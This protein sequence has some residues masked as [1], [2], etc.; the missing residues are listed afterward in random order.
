MNCTKCT[1]L[2]ASRTKIVQPDTPDFGRPCKLL[3]I[4]EAPG[5]DEDRQGK[6][7]VG[8]SGKVLHLLLEEHGLRRGYEYGCANIVRCRPPGNRK[9]TAAEIENCLPYLADTILQAK[10]KA[11]LLI[12][13]TATTVFLGGGALFHHVDASRKLPV[14]R[15]GQFSPAHPVLAEGLAAMEEIIAIPMPHT[16]PLAWNRKDPNGTRWS[17]IGREQ[18]ERVARLLK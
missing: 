5:S 12:G 14:V 1:S 10:P 6:G 9:P 7:F 18:V 15:F 4:G 13:G 3:V 17:I 11:I 16:S 8:R 2:C